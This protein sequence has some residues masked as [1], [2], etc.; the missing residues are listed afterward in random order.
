MDL[1]IPEDV[2]GTISSTKKTAFKNAILAMKAFAVKIND[3]KSNEEMTVKASWHL[4]RHDDG[5][6]CEPEHEI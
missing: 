6:P 3:G 5:L 4:C 2:Y 1:F